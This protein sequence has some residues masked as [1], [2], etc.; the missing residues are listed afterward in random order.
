MAMDTFENQKAGYNST[1][2]GDSPFSMETIERLHPYQLILYLFLIGSS[3][4]FLF[5]VIAH[6][7]TRPNASVVENFT[8][9]KTFIVSSLIII[10]TSYFMSQTSE[11]FKKEELI[12][13]RNNLGII[14][15][16]G[17]SFCVCQYIGWLSMI[18]KGIL[19]EGRSGGVYLYILSGLHFIHILGGIFYLLLS[20]L[21]VVRISKD[22]IESLV[23]CTNPYEKLKL[24]LLVTFW[25]Y[26]DITWLFVFFYFL[27]SY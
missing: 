25:Y 23:A 22:P 20:F 24:N 5:L 10:V 18:D 2:N 11:L 7:A 21:Q 13:L 3:I 12:K 1:K 15:F 9:P 26:L 8:L 14:L 16:L 19:F 4:I 17:L 6:F 27:V